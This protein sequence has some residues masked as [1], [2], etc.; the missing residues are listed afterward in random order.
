MG[1]GIVVADKISYLFNISMLEENYFI[2]NGQD[3]REELPLWLG[4]LVLPVII[5]GNY[6]DYKLPLIFKNPYAEQHYYREEDWCYSLSSFYYF[7]IRKIKSVHLMTFSFIV[8]VSYVVYAVTTVTDDYVG[9]EM[10][11][12]LGAF[13]GTCRFI[14]CIF[15]FYKLVLLQIF[16]LT[17]P[18]GRSWSFPSSKYRHSFQLIFSVVWTCSFQVPMV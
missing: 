14:H 4:C 3:D 5:F 11:A 17:L 2:T 16:M 7:I 18:I 1:F 12:L 10:S 8:I 15:T 13:M 6:L 9:E